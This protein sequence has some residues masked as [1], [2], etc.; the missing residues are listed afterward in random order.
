MT[1]PLAF[2]H[3]NATTPNA[4]TRSTPR[5]APRSVTR[6]RCSTLCT[7]QRTEDGRTYRRGRC[8][9]S[10]HVN[11]RPIRAV[12]VESTMHLLHL[13]GPRVPARTP[14]PRTR[15]SPAVA[16]ARGS[17]WLGGG[18]PPFWAFEGAL[19]V[20]LRLRTRRRT[21]PGA[22]PG[23]S[24]HERSPP[25]R[26]CVALCVKEARPTARPEA[27][28]SHTRARTS[29]EGVCSGRSSSGAR[30]R[31]RVWRTACR[32]GSPRLRRRTRRSAL[33]AR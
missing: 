21:R 29:R 27:R 19:C 33:A 13:P 26:A 7:E 10:A 3:R 25:P 11:V 18:L 17:R 1:R 6:T 12:G 22:L 9:Q 32:G 30:P 14:A 8:T 2:P 28:G 31:A 5:P 20:A 24:A 4:S 16:T 15:R 23:G